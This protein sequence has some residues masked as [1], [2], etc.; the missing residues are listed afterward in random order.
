MLVP[1]I[2]LGLENLHEALCI[3]TG[4]NFVPLPQYC[5]GLLPRPGLTYNGPVFAANE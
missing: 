1:T 3:K 2:C 4:L 5:G